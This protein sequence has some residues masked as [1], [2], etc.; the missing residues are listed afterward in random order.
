M[1]ELVIGMDV[2]S[3]T[4]KAVVI[5]PESKNILWHDYQRH[6]TKQPEKVLEL[7]TNIMAAFPDH[8]ADGWR[9]FLT[10]SGSGPLAAPT[11]GK[12]VQE[13]NAV[14]LAVEHKHPDVQSVIELGGQDAKII[15][16]KLA[17]EEDGQKTATTSMNDKCASGTGATIDKCMIKVGAEPGFATSLHFNDEKLHHVA[18]K[19][20]V[21][22]ETDIVNL[23]KG[24]IPKDE[25]LNSLADAIV[26]QNLSVLT[27]GNTLKPRVLL[28]G[29]PNTYL[30]FLREC[31]Q[32]RIPETWRD[33]GFDYP[34]DVPIEELIFVPPNSDL[35]AA[36]GAA[37]YG[38]ADG[39]DAG[40][41]NG[42][43]SL[44]DFIQN[45]RRA[46]LG[47]QAGPPLSANEGET[48]SFVDT[49]KIP[50]FAPPPLTRGMTYR[51]VIGLDGG[52]TSSK[53]VV[54]D[55]NSEI[56]CKAYQLSKGNPLQDTKELVQKLLDHFDDQG[57]KLEVVGF[58]ATGYAAD[59]L[60]ETVLAD[61]N[62]VETVAHM[63]S[64]VHFFGD[65]DVVCDIGGQDIKVLFMKNGDI[66]NFKLSN[67]CSAG[68][69]MLLQ[70]MADQFGIP[71]T[72][73][74]DTAF[75]ATL[76]PKFSYGCAVF[77]D[78]D[79][80]NFQK[81]GYQKEELLAGLA[82]VLPKNVWQYVVQI[83][84]LASL[85]RKFV[86]QGGTQYNLAALKAQ[87]DYIKQRVPDAE[88]F[89][90]P[91]TGE[92]GA[93][94]A[95]IETLRRW[96]RNGKTRFI[97]V[98]G[99]LDLEYTART[100]D[101]TTCH[102][103][104]NECKRTFIDSKRPDGSQARYIS[105]FSCEKGTVE[106]KEAMLELMAERKKTAAAFPNLVD[107]ESKRAF[108]HLY[109]A[110]PLPAEGTPIDD[111]KV[112]KTLLRVKREKVTRPFRRSSAEAAQ[113]RKTL[114]VGIPRVLNV[115]STAPFFRAYFE[116]LGLGRSNIVFSDA[117]SEE[118]W[119]EGGKYGSIDPCFPS[120]VAQA[121]VHNLLFHHH[122]PER[123]RPL[124]YIFFPI[125]TH[126][127][128]FVQD[129][130]DNASCPIV[131]GTPDVMKAA[132]T[133]EVDFFAQRGIEYLAPALSFSE[134]TLLAHRMFQTF[135]ERLGITEDE[136]DHACREAWKAFDAFDKDLQEKGRAILETVEAEDRIA[137][138][139]LNRP[140]HSDPGLNHGIPEEFQILG[141]PILSIR[142]I[143]K[144]RD[145]LDRYYKDELERGV[146]KTPL[147]LN[148]VWP[149]NYS[150]NSA[151]KVWGAAFAAHH[152]NVA[153]LDLSSF[154]CGHDAPT[155]G[156]IDSILQ[157]SRT[158]AAALHDLDANKPGGSIKIRVK[159]YAHSLRLQQ[160]RLE[161][162]SVKK[163]ELARRIDEK[164]LELLRMK[165]AQ[166]EGVKR[167]DP[168]LEKHIAELAEK[169]RAYEAPPISL[170]MP[171]GMIQL[172]KKLA[173]GSIERLSTDPPAA[174]SAAE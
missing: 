13:V 125:L 128:N 85:G 70:A 5:E 157:T 135:G 49:Y 38:I 174:A 102:F 76:A 2:G 65:I 106:S 33:R 105:G 50:K 151:Q 110:A 91:H 113:R 104:P 114:R 3:T 63:M 153:V 163:R 75:Q 74:A 141:Y 69:G 171:K 152:P 150:V 31:W 8:P 90:H 162:L 160:E 99:I 40:R 24:G 161:D 53:A 120:K 10:G 116:V 123:K 89:V 66:Q 149:E 35:Y 9:M 95:A 37:V 12:F 133:K 30:P 142:S 132:F 155:Y 130:Q 83:P 168:E 112:T 39:G 17:A 143:P 78:S 158:P 148:H 86:L 97:G 139:V 61:V 14:T 172:G 117:T 170:E 138:L 84:R 15:M 82:Q 36:F 81:E 154:K 147:E 169:V 28:L 166:L 32:K 25:V 145:Y 16:F 159:T 101:S 67:S 136:N 43:E 80:V 4:V 64:A 77:L 127:N 173:D 46:R 137:I 45:G 94:G 26:L 111:V 48:S 108:V 167:K 144:D 131:A 73:Y 134:P 44:R 41:F 71:V 87:V 72:E 124:H 47:E 122:E 98:K 1:S 62:I 21:F 29:G 19:C 129:T 119:V 121:H 79:R 56:L 59:V 11:G 93:I 54:I 140:Y 164:R 165:Q 34:K 103:C 146:I 7:L 109:D 27:R 51:G 6:H 156:L 60:D 107:Y 126:V 23:V 100:D 88:V 18:A 20:G 22:A 52:S 92:A 42:L 68:N 118:M 96:K 55:E 115:Y 57:A 58:G